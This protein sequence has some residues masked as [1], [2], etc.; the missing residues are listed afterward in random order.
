[1]GAVSRHYL[2]PTVKVLSGDDVKLIYGNRL[3]ELVLMIV[4]GLRMTDSTGP[5]NSP[6]LWVHTEHQCYPISQAADQPVSR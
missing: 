4:S 2:G 3:N 5:Y 6:P 1:M